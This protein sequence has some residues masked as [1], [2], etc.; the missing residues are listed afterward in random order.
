[1]QYLLTTVECGLV[2]LLS[3]GL[4]RPTLNDAESP[5]RSLRMAIA[6]LCLELLP[7]AIGLSDAFAFTD[8][9]LDRYVL[10][11]NRLIALHIVAI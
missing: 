10:S 11:I 2:D 8:W 4:I 1:L 3:F 7:N 5:A 9:E 6:E